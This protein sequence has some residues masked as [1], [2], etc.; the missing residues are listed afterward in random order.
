MANLDENIEEDQAS[1]A[2]FDF[3]KY[4]IS[5]HYRLERKLLGEAFELKKRSKFIQKKGFVKDFHLCVKHNK[6]LKNFKTCF[7]LKNKQK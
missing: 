3:N 6:N 2:Q 1:L 7:N 4:M 5:I